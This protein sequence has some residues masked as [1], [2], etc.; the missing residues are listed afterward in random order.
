MIA[1]VI[2]FKLIIVF[3]RKFGNNF[4]QSEVNII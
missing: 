4:A 3:Q 1:V 2:E